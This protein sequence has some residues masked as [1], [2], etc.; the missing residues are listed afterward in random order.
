MQKHHAFPRCHE[1]YKALFERIRRCHQ[2]GGLGAEVDAG[3]IVKDQY[4]PGLRG[5]RVHE[6]LAGRLFDK[7]MANA[8]K[9]LEYRSELVPL[10]GMALYRDQNIKRT[11]IVDD[12]HGV[13][14]LGLLS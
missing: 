9:R 14:T 12:A 6:G 4:V 8:L 5:V 7:G 10:E 2:A 13:A 3:H 11:V 1:V